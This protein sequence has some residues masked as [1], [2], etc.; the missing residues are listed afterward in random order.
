MYRDISATSA[1]SYSSVRK[2]KSQMPLSS[3]QRIQQKLSLILSKKLGSSTQRLDVKSFAKFSEDPFVNVGSMAQ[4]SAKVG[5]GAAKTSSDQIVYIVETDEI[6]YLMEELAQDETI[7]AEIDYPQY[8]WLS[9]GGTD[10]A[11][12]S[13]KEEEP[14]IEEP[15]HQEPATPWQEFIVLQ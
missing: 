3:E 12:T 2:A 1:D 7:Y 10:T 11:L 6:A 5:V 4:R 9:D 15:V 14:V 13:L 8:K